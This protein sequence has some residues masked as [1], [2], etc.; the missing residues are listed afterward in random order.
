MSS[1]QVL[2][3]YK[4]YL[5]CLLTMKTCLVFYSMTMDFVCWYMCACMYVRDQASVGGAEQV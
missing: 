2:V 4:L 5:K 3:N 1:V